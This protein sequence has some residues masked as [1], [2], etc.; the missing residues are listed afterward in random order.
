MVDFEDAND[1]VFGKLAGFFQNHSFHYQSFLDFKS[2]STVL[3]L[4]APSENVDMRH[5]MAYEKRHN[6]LA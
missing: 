3:S 4:T 2:I 6:V 1:N 5:S